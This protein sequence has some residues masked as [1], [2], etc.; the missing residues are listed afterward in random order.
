MQKR[1]VYLC[2]RPDPSVSNKSN[3]SLISC[4]CSSVSSGFPFALL[5]EDP[6]AV[7]ATFPLIDAYTHKMNIYGWER[8]LK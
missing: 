4:F 5:R 2:S 3:A 6:L 1:N 7:V 8:K